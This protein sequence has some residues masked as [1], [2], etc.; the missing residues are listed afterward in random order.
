MQ[1]IHLKDHFDINFD[2]ANYKMNLNKE[3]QGRVEFIRWSIEELCD[4]EIN[5]TLTK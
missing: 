1:F 3:L 4:I 2:S 5:F